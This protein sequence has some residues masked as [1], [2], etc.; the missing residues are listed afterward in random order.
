VPVAPYAHWSPNPA[1]ALGNV[2]FP[3]PCKQ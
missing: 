2:H 3:S 1:A